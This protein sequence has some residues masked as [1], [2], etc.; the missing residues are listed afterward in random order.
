MSESAREQERITLDTL[1]EEIVCSV[2]F[3]GPQVFDYVKD[4]S[5]PVFT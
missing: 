4:G 1:E 5:P 2:S 3:G